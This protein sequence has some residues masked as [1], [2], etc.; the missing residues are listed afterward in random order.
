MRYPRKILVLVVAALTV[1]SV[2]RADERVKIGAADFSPT[3]ALAPGQKRL[4]I[5]AFR[6][7]KR[8]VTNA[9]FLAFVLKHPEWRRDRAPSLFVDGD[10]LSH[11]SAPDELGNTALPR[12]PVTRVSWFAARAYCIAAD[13]RLPDWSEWELAAAADEKVAD[14][15]KDAAWRERILEWYSHPGNQPLA[16]VGLNPPNVYGVQDLQGLIWEW[17]ED[18]G[19][20]MVSGDSRNQGDPDKLA[21]CGAGAL[22]AQ[23]RE[24]YP[25]LMRIGFLSALE[26]RS[27]AHTLGFRCAADASQ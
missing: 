21:F 27:T 16:A 5:R 20:L 1:V 4:H 9:Q 26:G 3:L 22:S 18:F 11:W 24:N 19:A 14:A 17:V 7:D 10:Y 12:Q 8:P 25:I 23:D 15:R 6:L 2:V 13:A